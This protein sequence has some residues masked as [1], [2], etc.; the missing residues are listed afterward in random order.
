MRVK[1]KHIALFGN[2]GSGNLGN[3]ASLKAMLNFIRH[4]QHDAVVACICYG[5]ETAQAEHKVATI[6]IKLLLP[7]NRWLVKLNRLFFEIP[8]LL[9]DFVRAFY[10]AR[11]F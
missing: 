1:A 10:L 3:E 5:C 4:T 7:K 11:R 2:F 9:V 8:L 6:P